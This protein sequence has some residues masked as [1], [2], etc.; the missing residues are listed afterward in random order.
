MMAHTHDYAIGASA[1]AL[2]YVEELVAN[3]VCPPP[4]G[5]YVRPYAV[6]RQAASGL[7][8]GDGYPECDWEW[9]DCRPYLYDAL[10]T[11]IGA[12][13]Q[14]APVY[15]QTRNEDRSFSIY[16]AVMHRPKTGEEGTWDLNFWRNLKIRFTMLEIQ[17]V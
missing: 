6:Y 17:V 16:K 3:K 10:M 2:V 7:E 5:S 13:N 8:Y 9:V 14:S 15:I 11:Y 12:G 1:E 4:G